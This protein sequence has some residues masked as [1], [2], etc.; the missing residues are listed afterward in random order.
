VQKDYSRNWATGDRSPGIKGVF[1]VTRRPDLT[2]EAFAKHWH[3]GHAPLARK[4][5]IGLARYV[6]NVSL[7][8][9]TVGA[10]DYDGFATLHFLTADDM[11]ERY[12]DS[13][14]GF[15]I[16]AADVRRFIGTPSMQMNCGEYILRD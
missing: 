14:Q 12:Y 4:H 9:L 1:M 3:E 16:I 10:P 5:H 11:R 2:R 13:P 7:G 15:E 8:P 6:Q